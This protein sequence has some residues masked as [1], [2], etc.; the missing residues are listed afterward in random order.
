M[1][2]MERIC[3]A[4]CDFFGPLFDRIMD[5]LERICFAVCDF[6][7]QVGIKFDDFDYQ[8]A[9]VAFLSSVVSYYLWLV[10]SEMLFFEAFSKMESD[11]MLM[12]RDNIAPESWKPAI[13]DFIGQIEK[14][15]Y[16]AEE[17][18]KE[19]E[20]LTNDKLETIITE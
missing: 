10:K 6:L 7:G 9:L 14:D 4:I 15:I 19:F 8:H 18:Y 16:V 2:Y 13:N 17:S 1:D 5:L 20:N 11:F 3:C 12:F